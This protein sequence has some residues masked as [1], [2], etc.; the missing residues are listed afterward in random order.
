MQDREVLVFVEVRYR[1]SN[2]FG[3]PAETIDRRKQERLRA[4]ASHYLM[5]HAMDCACR[6]DV[7]AVSGGEALIE[8][9]QDAFS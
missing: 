5:K 7:V 8:W 9:L 4:A 3:S 6:F 1:H 2:A